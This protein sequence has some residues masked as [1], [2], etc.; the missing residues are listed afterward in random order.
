MNVIDVVSGESRTPSMDHHSVS[1]S[2]LGSLTFAPSV[3]GVPHDPTGGVTI[4]TSGGFFAHRRLRVD[5]EA[6][7]GVGNT[8]SA[9][10]LQ[11]D[12][13]IL[14][15]QPRGFRREV[16]RGSVRA[17]QVLSSPTVV[18]GDGLTLTCSVRANEGAR[19]SARA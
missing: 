8:R 5:P 11:R 19:A 1:T 10:S 3:T 4:T 16:H 17:L 14:G 12:R 13:E 2:S 18:C 15:C 7:L 6:N 9:R